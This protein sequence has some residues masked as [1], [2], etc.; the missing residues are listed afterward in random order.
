MFFEFRRQFP[1]GA[2]NADCSD[3]S[4]AAF[5]EAQSGHRSYVICYSP[6]I[7]KSFRLFASAILSNF[8]MITTRQDENQKEKFDHKAGTAIVAAVVMASCP[9]YGDSEDN[10]GSVDPRLLMTRNECGMAGPSGPENQENRSP[11]GTIAGPLL[12]APKAQRSVQATSNGL[13]S[14]YHGKTKLHRLSKLAKT[15]GVRNIR[16]TYPE[17][18]CV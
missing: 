3:Y 5:V 15:Y 11:G 16:L 1:L 14:P 18:S 7:P 17:V 8:T 10:G 12:P 6:N 4:M 2:T 9:I 13:W